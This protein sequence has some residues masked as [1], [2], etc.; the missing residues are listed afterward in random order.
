MKLLVDESVDQ[1]VVQALR[2]EGHEVSYVA[3]MD[4]RISDDR[5]LAQANEYGAL[6]AGC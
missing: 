4:P 5:V 1:Q 2:R 3:E 6:L